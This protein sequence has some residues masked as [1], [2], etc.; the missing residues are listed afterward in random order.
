M[1]P[2]AAPQPLPCHLFPDD[3]Q[4]E[5]VLA[6]EGGTKAS[7]PPPL[8]TPDSQG[9]PPHREGG[10]GQQR[11]RGGRQLDSSTTSLLP[12]G[13]G[14]GVHLLGTPLLSGGIPPSLPPLPGVL[15][16]PMKTQGFLQVPRCSLATLW[17]FL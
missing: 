7:S 16:L 17:W 14:H 12:K 11:G 3:S 5:G 6:G 2:Q 1:W 4:R 8:E 13:G 10:K 9:D 15:H